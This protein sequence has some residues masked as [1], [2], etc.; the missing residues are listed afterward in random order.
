MTT[1]LIVE[2][3]A[4]TLK[5][6]HRAL[7]GHGFMVV[8]A[9][10]GATALTEFRRDDIS[11]VLQDLVLPDLDGIELARR[12]RA[13]PR[14]HEVPILAFSGMLSK[15]DE[16]RCSTAGF[17][18]FIVKPIEPSHLIQIV[19][20][21][22]PSL[23][24]GLKPVAQARRLVLADDDPVQRKLATF[25]LQRAGYTVTAAAD[26]QE[27]F[28]LAR[29]LRPDAIVSDVLMPRLD[30]FGLCL[31]ARHDPI[32]AAT[33]IVLVT[34][35]YLE[36][37]DRELARRTGANDLVLRTPDLAAVLSSLGAALA[38]PQPRPAPVPVDPAV[39][40]ERVRR[41]MN[42]LERQVTLNAGLNQRAA[43]LAAELSVLSA[44]SEAV[45]SHDDVDASLRQALAACF[46]AGGISMGALY[47]EEDGGRRVI[48]FGPSDP[49]TVA[50]LSTFFRE[51]ELLDGVVSGQQMLGVPSTAMAESTTRDLLARA[52]ARS[53]LLLPLGH[54]GVP[55]GALL[56]VSRSV[57]LQ[58]ADRIPFANAVG[59]QISLALAIK[60]AFDAKDAS[61]HA[62]LA[63]A[64]TL[65]SIL[66]SIADAV[67]VVDKTGALALSNPA[68]EKLL[69]VREHF[70]LSDQ[71]TRMPT[72]ADP[73]TRAHRGT[74]TDRDELYVQRE[75]TAEG[76]WL[77]VNVRPLPMGGGVAVYRDVTVER[78]ANTQLMISDRMASLG[79]LAAGVGH[80]INNPLAA[81]IANLDLAVSDLKRLASAYPSIDFG[82]LPAELDDAVGASDRVRQIV[83]DLRLFSRGQQD[84]VGIV[85][86]NS[87]VESSIRMTWNEIRHRARLTRVLDNVRPVLVNEA[88]LGQV[89]INLIVNAVH[90]IPAGNAD[91]HEIRVATRDEGAFVRIAIA[92]TGVGMTPDIMAR[93]FTP[94]FTTKPIGVGTGLGLAICR[95]LVDAAGGKIDVSSTPDHGSTFS[96]LLPATDATV[97]PQRPSRSVLARVRGRVLVIDD[98]A[99]MVTTIRRTLAA[100]EVVAFTEAQRGLD[101]IARGERFDVILCDL[102]MPTITGMDVYDTIRRIA[103]EQLDALVFVTG[104]AFMPHARTFV[105]T[106]ANTTLEKP[107]DPQALV[108]LVDKLVSRRRGL[109]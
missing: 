14:G 74:A 48:T 35:S 19:R 97:P 28:E 46:D 29:E 8:D 13:M 61:E 64:T 15:G 24:P 90:A 103:P 57:D 109:L 45:A 43:L 30:G 55:L 25:R 49:A 78:V 26:G 94:F 47:I 69:A 75:G 76:T 34:N 91:A 7:T 54:R 18:D 80:E 27:A 71:V 98:D 63:N 59:G 52:H 22:L 53:M 104:G 99:M 31:R 23:D 93:L 66:D 1:I 58:S 38:D 105:E 11:L 37:A 17:D 41:V 108:A 60:R 77:S 67:V 88:R 82:E 39:E 62:A 33:P 40:R 70:Y 32:L 85:D 89:L 95:R 6:V 83:R 92:D 10:D 96:V 100:H 3:N 44:I 2:D 51:E 87:V 68:A 4:I 79:T 20:A 50:D 81:V 16:A 84:K 9:P 101:E 102:M 65:R 106:V 36:A 72:E 5:I 21:H 73:L 56:M 12:L 42:Q 86:V 107:F